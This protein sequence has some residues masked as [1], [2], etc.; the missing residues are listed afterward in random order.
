MRQLFRPLALVI[1]ATLIPLLPFLGWAREIN[2]WYEQFLNDP[3]PPVWMA[4]FVLLALS[5]DIFLPV[6]S[7]IVST[8]AGSQ[9]GI[10]GATI[11]SFVGMTI[12]AALGFAV[13][14]WW[15][16]PVAKWFTKDEDLARMEELTAKLGPAVLVI[17]RAVPIL[18]EASVLLVG[19][20]R[21]SWRA[22]LP[23]V[24]LA[25]L[26]VSLVYAVSGK[27]LSFLYAMAGAVVLPVAAACVVRWIWPESK[28]HDAERSDVV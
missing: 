27:H 22:F 6:P 24:L 8:L 26:G 2:A 12:G 4:L 17:T 11:T 13:A 16:R 18:A 1:L 21:M 28:V 19:V 14:R 3:P 15:G 9:L 10:P 7:S 20:N 5:A 23:P 25:N